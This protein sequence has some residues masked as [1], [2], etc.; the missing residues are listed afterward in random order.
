MGLIDRLDNNGT[1]Y[2]P[3]VSSTSLS[4]TFG[5]ALSKPLSIRHKNYSI[6]GNP[7]ITGNLVA[8]YFP[9]VSKGFGLLPVPS[10]LDLNGNSPLGPLRDPSFP[11]WNN[12][13]SCGVYKNCAPE[14]GAS[15][16]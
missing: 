8:D 11:F 14:T 6:S 1:N 3:G 16:I 7:S 5:N 15:H 4:P 12:S 2:N 9:M 10:L 13:F